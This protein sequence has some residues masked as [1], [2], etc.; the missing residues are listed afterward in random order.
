[1]VNDDVNR[2][3]DDVTGLLQAWGGGE[4]EA[5]EQLMRVVYEELRRRAAARLR[6]ERPGHVL[7]PT[8]L[9]HE[10]YLRL[11]GQRQTDWQNRAHFFAVAS[12]M[13]RR[14]LVD[15]AR[16][17]QTAKRSGGWAR[18]TIDEASAQYDPPD[19]NILDL[20]AALSELASFDPRKSR[21]AELRF[22]GGLS[23][24]ETAAALDISRATVD[25]EWQ[26]ARAWLYR[27]ISHTADGDD[28]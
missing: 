27:R 18:V 15:H 11:V 2:A 17:R 26:A 6:R 19:V 5:R 25:R 22:F 12:E 8:A 4:P 10:A 7:Q 21:V 28:T 16:R 20:D 1:V 13:M 14:I 24:E 9:V 23:P 3:H